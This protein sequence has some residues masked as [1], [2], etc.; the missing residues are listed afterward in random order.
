MEKKVILVSHGKLSEA[1]MHSVQM[2]IGKNEA[3]S[4]Y[5]IMPVFNLANY[6]RIGDGP[7]K[8]RNLML[9]QLKQL[10]HH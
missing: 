5:G 10:K 1:M 7:L 2:I 3:L 9:L 4:C 8:E 6:G